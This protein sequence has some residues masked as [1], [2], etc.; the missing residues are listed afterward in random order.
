MLVIYQ[1]SLH[2]ARSTKY[3]IWTEISVGWWYIQYT[4]V[5]TAH[6]A[7]QL[8]SSATR[9][10]LVSNQWINVQFLPLTE[11]S[12]A[13]RSGCVCTWSMISFTATETPPYWNIFD[14]VKHVIKKKT[15]YS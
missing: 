5:L 12:P 4:I 8:H 6:G 10:L 11:N 14:Y 9:D 1:E 3:K 15:L 2:D 13:V 7:E